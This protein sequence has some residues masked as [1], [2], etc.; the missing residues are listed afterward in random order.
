[1]DEPAQPAASIPSASKPRAPDS[2]HRTPGIAPA[3]DTWLN[4]WRGL[5]DNPV[6]VY[7]P[8]MMR[9]R[10]HASRRSLPWRIALTLVAMTALAIITRLNLAASGMA[11][12]EQNLIT[13]GV[14]ILPAFAVL[15][16]RG[17]FMVFQACLSALNRRPGAQRAT[18]FEDL[19]GNSHLTDKELIIG[20]GRVL[21]PVLLRR[22][23]AATVLVFAMV[24]LVAYQVNVSLRSVAQSAGTAMVSVQGSWDSLLNKLLAAA[25]ASL[26]S[27]AL[28]G[29]LA[30]VLCCLWL[31]ALGRRRA[32]E[33]SISVEAAILATL[34]LL[35]S[36]NGLA[37]FIQYSAIFT[38]L[39][40]WH[41]WGELA[42]TIAGF[43]VV[44]VA[45]VGLGWLALR[46][47]G[48]R[49]AL[50]VLRPMGMAALAIDAQLSDFLVSRISNGLPGFSESLVLACSALLLGNQLAYLSY[51]N[52]DNSGVDVIRQV[53]VWSY[54]PLLLIAF[55]LVLIVPLSRLAVDS[56]RRFRRGE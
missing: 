30:S 42:M 43:S 51:A 5:R 28:A 35:G 21:M 1:M 23:V 54:F 49:Q 27:V 13:A 7:V 33:A 53:V 10:A 29:M 15:Y 52:M 11:P 20:L 4:A 46:S 56:L 25:P 34:Q 48:L 40:S 41:G 3:P 24:L 9:R 55:Q 2:G 16:F 6:A 26:V 12:V 22:V 17:L 50:P 19:A 14:V 39:S 32:S 45:L 38:P 44:T 18:L 47:G 36:L 8:L 31:L 37:I